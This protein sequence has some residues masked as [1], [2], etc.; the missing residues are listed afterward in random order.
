MTA[1]GDELTLGADFPP[2]T[3]EQWRK[4]ALAALRKSGAATEDTALEQVDEL[5]ATTTYDG[6]SIAAL[7]TPDSAPAGPTGLPG[8][9]P[10]VRGARA[11][12]GLDGGWDV[13]QRHTGEDPK[14]TREAILGDLENGATSIWLSV[15]DDALPFD[16][17]PEALDGVY[18]DLAAVVLD[19]GKDFAAAGDAWFD[20]LAARGVDPRQVRGGLGADPLGRLA[21]TGSLAG[22]GLG[23][24][25]ALAGRCVAEAPGIRAVTIDATV[26]HDAGG[27]DAEELGCAAAA[28]V[29]YLR[30][31]TDAG[32]PVEAA[33]SQL[34]F[35]Y[36]ATAD[37]FAT[38]A[39][40]RAARRIWARIAELSGAPDAGGQRQHAV[41]SA[42]MMTARDPWV[43]LLRTTIAAFAAGVGGADAVTVLPFDHGLGRPDGFS[44]RLARNT[45]TLLVEEAHVARVIDPAGGSWYV[46]N[47]TDELA[48]AAW[49]W[50]TGIEQAGGI[51]AAL[52]SGLVADR[53]AATWQRR[54][55][56]LAH[57]RDPI[58]GVSEF[59]N[60]A[61][62]VPERRPAAAPVGGGLP[63]HRY[64]E[65]FERL[66]DRSDAYL[67]ETGS[68]PTVSLVTLGSPAAS[69]PRV[70]FAT[71][72]F[73]A[74]GIAVTSSPGPVV[75]LC[76]P[77]KAYAEQAVDL[78]TELRAA[79][80]QRVILAGRG[81]FSGIDRYVY[82]GCD[83]VAALTATL[84]DLGVPE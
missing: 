10:F 65:A 45:Q 82:T 67:A 48:R 37:Q 20:L 40:L 14:E 77:D 27:S 33:L 83:A 16:A 41:T 36:A 55:S 68:R 17:L 3:V 79:G 12:G 54:E 66:R 75:C 69:G 78:T 25:A 38:I 39:K 7:H 61:E 43:N 13:R 1:P 28:G 81:D 11:S 70:T 50:F 58:T 63:R 51:A 49:E 42:A 21:R 31:L 15:G 73:A 84:A 76:G 8:Q 64:A 56:N 80:T 53:L 71:N 26:Y 18:L 62:R 29:A 72:L 47:C 5:L 30:A 34:E 24:A 22:T 44:R 23:S 35:R 46:E 60:L 6:P 19:P 32:L 4:L 59:P 74:G 52:G 57:R 9:R 2:A